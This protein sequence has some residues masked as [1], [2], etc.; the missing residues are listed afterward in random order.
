LV[1]LILN[2]DPNIK[3]P[4]MW[5]SDFDGTLKPTDKPVSEKDLQALDTLGSLGVTRVVAT[6]RTIETFLEDWNPDI[7]IDYLIS[8]TGLG[9]SV[10]GP[11]GPR[12]LLV[13]HTFTEEDANKAIEA[14]ESIGLGF[15]LS[16]PPP[17]AHRFYIKHPE[18]DT[19]SC[20]SLR[21]DKYDSSSSP[22]RGERG[23]PM[24]QVLIMGSPELMAR[25]RSIFKEQMPHLS[26]V[27]S[28][29]PYG[30]GAH[31]LEVYPPGVSKGKA[32]ENLAGTLGFSS[33]D[34]VALGND[35]NDIDLL[36]FAGEAFISSEAPPDLRKLYRNIPPAGTGPLAYVLKLFLE[37]K[38][39]SQKA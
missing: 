1:N 4:P 37:N 19:L 36:S 30:D 34:V 27:I 20:F 15:F 16:F 24:S 31:W 14:A 33:K 38:G 28:T 26:F 21:A 7:R 11:E 8:S 23:F 39:Y 35:Y 32:A 5:I 17:E 10:F 6:G 2:A 25:T 13:S 18:K 29:S 9:T 22:Y 12:E 3:I